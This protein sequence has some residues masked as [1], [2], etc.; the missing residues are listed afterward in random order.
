MIM[1]ESCLKE[2]LYLLSS[3][4]NSDKNNDQLLLLTKYSIK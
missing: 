2:C 4:F 3:T 1:G